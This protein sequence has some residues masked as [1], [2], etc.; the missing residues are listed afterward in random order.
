MT[1]R[2]LALLGVASLVVVSSV[3]GLGLGLSVASGGVDAPATDAAPTDA[4]PTRAVPDRND[5]ESTTV[6]DENVSA[7][8]VRLVTVGEGPTF[9]GAKKQIVRGEADLPTG[10]ELV[11]VIVDEERDYLLYD[12]TSVEKEGTFRENVDLQGLPAGSSPTL[13]VLHDGTEVVNRTIDVVEPHEN[14]ELDSDWN[15][16]YASPG[17]ET[18]GGTTDLPE[19]TELTVTVHSARDP[20]LERNRTVT[21]R[22]DGT[23]QATF[24]LEELSHS[25]HFRVSVF[26]DG[27]RL[28]YV[29]GLVTG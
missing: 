21:V 24:D 20:A 27:T 14:T 22:P 19:G 3:A 23:F 15:R 29:T 12:T 8:A 6:E 18:F 1:L 26:H 9:A 4:E 7:D 16:V 28:D 25:D 5:E 11:V 2:R 17:H 10:S 13:I